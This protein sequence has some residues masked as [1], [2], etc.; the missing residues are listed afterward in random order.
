MSK[1]KNPSRG[2]MIEKYKIPSGRGKENVRRSLLSIQRGN[3][4]G[5]KIL[6]K[7]DILSKKK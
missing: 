2:D 4:K 3:G 6:K 5:S 7:I 1:I